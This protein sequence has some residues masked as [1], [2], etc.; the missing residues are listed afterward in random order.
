M[1]RM[2]HVHLHLQRAHT[3]KHV[4]VQQRLWLFIGINKA[5]LN[6]SY[7]VENTRN[8][9]VHFSLKRKFFGDLIS[10][11][12]EI[13]THWMKA[14][15]LLALIFTEPAF[16]CGRFLHFKVPSKNGIWIDWILKIIGECSE[17]QPPCDATRIKSIRKKWIYIYNFVVVAVVV[18]SMKNRKTNA[19]IEWFF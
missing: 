6:A 13:M 8:H 2:T 17:Y 5:K 12:C 16:V 18:A 15:L 4:Y 9:K 19:N 7:S 11:L 10:L 14:N 1:Y 3:D